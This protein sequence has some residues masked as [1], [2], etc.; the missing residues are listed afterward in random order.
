MENIALTAP[1]GNVPRYRDRGRKWDRV[2]GLGYGR[3][4]LRRERSWS[5]M[6]RWVLDN[7]VYL[8]E[9]IHDEDPASAPPWDRP[10]ALRLAMLSFASLPGGVIIDDR[11]SLGDPLSQAVILCYLRKK[12]MPLRWGARGKMHPVKDNDIRHLEATIGPLRLRESIEQYE[13]ESLD[14]VRHHDHLLEELTMFGSGPL[15]DVDQAFLQAKLRQEHGWTHL[16]IREYLNLYGFTNLSGNVGR[17]NH[18]Q[19]AKLMRRYA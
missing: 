6:E 1:Y 19:Y 18:A 2:L 8:G 16:R 10:A 11:E 15:R 14:L 4:N 7:D 3:P 17:W 13:T 5:L 9:V 12:N